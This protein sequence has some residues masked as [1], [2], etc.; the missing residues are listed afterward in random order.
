[1]DYNKTEFKVPADNFVRISFE[2]RKIQG[3]GNF[4]LCL[5]GKKDGKNVKSEV[6]KSKIVDSKTF[7]EYRILYRTSSNFD[8]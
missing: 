8:S 2:A 7:Q 4:Y 5:G 6:S 3:E 1:M